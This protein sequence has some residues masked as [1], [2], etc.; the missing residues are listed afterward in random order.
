M[1]KYGS[2]LTV[3]NPANTANAH[4]PESELDADFRRDLDKA[5]YQV[6]KDEI[7][8]D[9]MVSRIAR[10]YDLSF[11]KASELLKTQMKKRLVNHK[12]PVEYWIIDPNGKIYLTITKGG[13]EAAEKIANDLTKK[14]KKEYR[15]IGF[16]VENPESSIL[17]E[18]ANL[19]LYRLADKSLEIRLNKGTHSTVVGKPKT[20]ESGKRTM[21]RLER[22]PQNLKYI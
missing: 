1:A 17:Y 21:D 5:A 14:H 12:N 19:Y 9:Y 4:N 2:F 7:E 22:Y 3:S 11:D 13:R 20:I 16:G 10:M 8:F 18:T 15:V 6:N